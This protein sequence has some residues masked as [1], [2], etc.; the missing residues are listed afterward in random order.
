M[1]MRLLQCL[2]VIIIIVLIASG[3]SVYTSIV[4]CE[5]NFYL[6]FLYT[7]VCSRVERTNYIIMKLYRC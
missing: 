7:M 4:N 3:Q 2:V 1:G 6:N 5:Y